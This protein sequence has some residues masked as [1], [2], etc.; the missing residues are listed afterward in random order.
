[1]L[2]TTN[3]TMKDSFTIKGQWYL[4]TYTDSQKVY[5][6]LNYTP[7]VI[8]L[9]LE[10]NFDFN[11]SLNIKNK[12]PLIFG[13]SDTGKTVILKENNISSLD[14]GV[15]GKIKHSFHVMEM[16][17]SNKKI[18]LKDL[19]KIDHI[20]F[21]FDQ[22]EKWD[23]RSSISFQVV[24]E[25]NDYRINYTQEDIQNISNKF[26]LKHNG[27]VLQQIININEISEPDNSYIGF[28]QLKS[29]LMYKV[30]NNEITLEQSLQWIEIVRHGFSILM[31]TNLN[32]LNIEFYLENK[33]DPI[34]HYIQYYARFQTS[35]P[36]D[37]FLVNHDSDG[38]NIEDY[39]NNFEKEYPRIKRLISGHLNHHFRAYYSTY[40]FI[41]AINILESFSKKYYI[42]ES[43]TPED[44]ED[45]KDS[46]LS[47]LEQNA[48]EEAKQYFSGNINYK[49]EN[50]L[51]DKLH[52]LFK[53]IPKE[54]QQI[55]IPQTSDN[56]KNNLSEFISCIVQTRNYNT[57]FDVETKYKKAVFDPLELF[58]LTRK[59]ECLFDVLILEKLG[60]P[61][62]T[63]KNSILNRRGIYR[64]IVNK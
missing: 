20:R 55:I 10:G 3:H 8:K 44:Y 9:N 56:D 24:N 42:S 49:P 47:L 53:R 40:D 12:I 4:P 31:G 35:I 16:F 25:T 19:E 48:S 39:L 46:L 22:F 50:S 7:E 34:P 11:T 59:L 18:N 32:L 30:N 38:L 17:I 1:M 63:I 52:T 36:E 28:E 5:G 29:F 23:T 6:V 61:T 37:T 41:L 14:I 2:N 33:N 58:E 51:S 45:V 64:D 27:L 21:N 15:P 43:V 62:S 60:I 57:H 26:I 13:D 54:I